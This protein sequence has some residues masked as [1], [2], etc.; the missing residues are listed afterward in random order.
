MGDRRTGREKTYDGKRTVHPLLR[1]KIAKRNVAGSKRCDRCRPNDCF[2]KE[3]RRFSAL[4]VRELLKFPSLSS[5]LFS[6]LNL[7]QYFQL[8]SI[9]DS[10]PLP[11]SLSALPSPL[12]HKTVSCTFLLVL[13]PSSQCFFGPILVFVPRTTSDLDSRRPKDFAG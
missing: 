10:S 3:A 1:L 9:C 7:S 13:F 6:S 11:P 5:L 8:P 4:F 12:S 2:P